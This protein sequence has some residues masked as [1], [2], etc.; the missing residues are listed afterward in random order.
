MRTHFE[1]GDLPPIP[2]DALV[3]LHCHEQAISGREPVVSTLAAARPEVSDSRRW[4]LRMAGSFGFDKQHYAV[5]MDI[6]E[7]VLLPAVRQAPSAMTIVANGFSCREQIRHATN[8]RACHF[9]PV[10][11]DTIGGPTKAPQYVHG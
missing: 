6:G 3:H 4:L 11:S 10:V 7:R 1:Q 8:R 5:S 2:G 9:A